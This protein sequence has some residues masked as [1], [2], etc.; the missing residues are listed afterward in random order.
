ME[1]IGEVIHDDVCKN[2]YDPERNTF[3]QY[4][5]SPDLDAALLL[6]PSVGFL[7]PDDP[8]VI[9]T[10]AAI[11]RE[12]L[13]DGFVLRY[14][15]RPSQGQNVDGLPGREGA[16]LACSFWMADALHLIGR[17]HDARNMFERLLSLRNDVG[18]LA[19][20]YDPVAHRQLGNVPQAFSHLPLVNTAHELSSGTDARHA[21][22]ATHA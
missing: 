11:E 16:F 17:Q 5:G 21:Q 15:T 2:G 8:R 19:E 10:I 9:G 6:I 1:G 14:P 18:L 4:Y 3:T 22:H 13:V 12:L 20:E 7:P